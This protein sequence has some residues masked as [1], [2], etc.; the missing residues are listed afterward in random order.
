MRNAHHLLFQENAKSFFMLLP[1]YLHRQCK[2][3]LIGLKAWVCLLSPF[4]QFCVLLEDFSVHILL[5]AGWPTTCFLFILRLLYASW[6]D[7]HLFHRL[8]FPFWKQQLVSLNQPFCYHTMC[9]NRDGFCSSL[10]DMLMGNNF[11]GVYIRKIQAAETEFP[12]Q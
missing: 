2:Q 7:K 9:Q 11:P 3:V 8:S 12:T 1:C 5:Q 6:S 10:W 4:N